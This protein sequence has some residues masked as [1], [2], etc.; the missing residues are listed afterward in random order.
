MAVGLGA[1]LVGA[2]PVLL[3]AGSL[4]PITPPHWAREAAETLPNSYVFEL[5]AVGH[6]VMDSHFCGSSLVLAFLADPTE[7]PDSSCIAEID[8][9]TFARP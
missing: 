6:G 7:E 3:L 2:L 9:P 5:P 1:I 8:P 4:D